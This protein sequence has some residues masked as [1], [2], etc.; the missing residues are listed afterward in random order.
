MEYASKSKAWPELKATIV[1][2]TD[3]LRD[4]VQKFLLTKS[5]NIYLDKDNRLLGVIDINDIISYLL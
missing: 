2:P 5:Q 1:Y 4:V 3:P